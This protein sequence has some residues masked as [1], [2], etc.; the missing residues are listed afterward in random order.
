MLPNCIQRAKKIFLVSVPIMAYFAMNR[1]TRLCVDASPFGLSA[2]L[3]QKDKTDFRII[4]YGSR[5][6]SRVEQKYS[7]TEREAVAIVWGVEHFHQYIYG[8]LFAIITDHKPLGVIYENASSKPSARIERW[9]LRLQPYN[10]KVIYRNGKEN[11]A[12][13]MSRHPANNCCANQETYT[14]EYI[15]FITKHAAPKA[16]TRNEIAKETKKDEFSNLL[17]VCLLTSK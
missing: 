9:V 17:Y 6:L 3:M 11:P 16:M 10:F 14:E 1:E 4:S 5:S 7:Q 2:I 13:Y 12:D 15:R 8:S